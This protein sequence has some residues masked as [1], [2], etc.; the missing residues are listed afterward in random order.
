[1]LV[2][3]PV[4]PLGFCEDA[5]IPACALSFSRSL[6]DF[7]AVEDLAVV[8][9][10]G[11]PRDM[12]HRSSNPDKPLADAA[13]T[14]AEVGAL[15][16]AAAV[17][18]RVTGVDVDGVGESGCDDAQRAF[19][20][21]VGDIVAAKDW[22]CLLLVAE[23]SRFSGALKAGG[24]VALWAGDPNVELT[25]D[26]EGRDVGGELFNISISV[27]RAAGGEAGEDG[28]GAA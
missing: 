17:D 26:A 11:P 10:D 28:E 20:A 24:E 8:L 9:E 16:D 18:V 5:Q 7:P 1:M 13:G 6:I 27:G 23:E 4:A 12:D 15:F 19:C 25:P 14:V 21:D 3:A 22:D 2:T